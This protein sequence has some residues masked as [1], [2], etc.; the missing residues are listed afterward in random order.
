MVGRARARAL[1]VAVTCAIGALPSVGIAGLLIIAGYVVGRIAR[2][3]AHNLLDAAGFNALVE[4]LKVHKL[5][6]KSEPS[7]VAGLVA[8]VLIMAHAAIAALDELDPEHATDLILL[9]SMAA[10]EA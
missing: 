8:M 1:A 9:E 3:V 10:A 6:G 2:A 7:A 4:R 5:F